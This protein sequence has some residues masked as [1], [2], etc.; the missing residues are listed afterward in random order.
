MAKRKKVLDDPVF[1]KL[2][3]DSLWDGRVR[4]EPFG[5]IAVL[6][7][8]GAKDDPPTD[9]QR[10]AVIELQERMPQLIGAV[11]QAIYKYYC[12]HRDQY[13]E[14]AFDPEEDTP[15]LSSVDEVNKVLQSPPLLVVQSHRQREL[16]ELKL[17]W[18]VTFDLE[19]S[20]YVALIGS[21]LQQVGIE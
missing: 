14:L 6:I 12:D 7:D 15:V 2:V 1:G 9:A 11:H 16:P 3:F 20:L 13:V 17:R 21:E 4:V 18:N 10:Q 5:E 8:A 19:H